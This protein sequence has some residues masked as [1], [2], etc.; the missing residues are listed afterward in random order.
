[1]S[2]IYSYY[3]YLVD[4]TLNQ[5]NRFHFFSVQSLYVVELRL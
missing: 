4:Y 3:Y 5:G 2:C 1:M